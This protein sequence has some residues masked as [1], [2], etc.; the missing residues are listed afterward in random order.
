VH[1]TYP[2]D[3]WSTPQFVI[4]RQIIRM[5]PDLR[6]GTYQLRLRLTDARD[7]D[8]YTTDLGSIAVEE[9]EHL[10][11]LPPV[12]DTLNAAFGN[13][14][15]LVGYDLA[16]SP[17]GEYGLTLVWQ[18][19]EEPAADYTVFVHVLD[20]DGTCCIW[21]QDIMPRQNQYPMSRWLSGEVVE[22]SYEIILPNDLPTGEYRI[23]V[24]LYVAETGQRLLAEMP[25]EL[26]SD[27]VMLR[28]IQIP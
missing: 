3:E 25:G 26:E 21:Q 28:P 12:E 23:E 9:A 5:P 24:G 19:I 2:F 22:D 27:M 15:N 6:A 16:R 10:F 20:Q 7:N 18:A 13:E 17:D 14:I 11:V 8:V 4:D 1:D